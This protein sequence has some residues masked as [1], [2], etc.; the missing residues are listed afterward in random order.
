MSANHWI[1]PVLTVLCFAVCVLQIR[2]IGSMRLDCERE[3]SSPGSAKEG[4]DG[5]DERAE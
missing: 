2:Q 4:F 1:W 5:D 3:A